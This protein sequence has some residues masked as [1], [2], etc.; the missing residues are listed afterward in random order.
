MARKISMGARREVL[1]A[2]AERSECLEGHPAGFVSTSNLGWRQTTSVGI[3]FWPDLGPNLPSAGEVQSLGHSCR[4]ST[5]CATRRP[6]AGS[7]DRLRA[8]KTAS[9]RGRA[10]RKNSFSAGS[11]KGN[12][13]A[14]A[15]PGTCPSSNSEYGRALLVCKTCFLRLLTGRRFFSRRRDQTIVKSQTIQIFDGLSSPSQCLFFGLVKKR[16]ALSV[17]LLDALDRCFICHPIF[18]CFALPPESPG[19]RRRGLP[20]AGLRI[21]PTRVQPRETPSRQKAAAT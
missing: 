14:P 6:A 1:S 11:R 21:T 5:M 10:A 8:T 3:R 17:Q 15:R 20:D 18:P 7:P 2:V 13:A 16:G 4:A 9:R 19:P 12:G